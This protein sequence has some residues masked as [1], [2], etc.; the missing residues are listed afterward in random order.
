MR[1]RWWSRRTRGMFTGPRSVFSLLC[2]LSVGLGVLRAVEPRWS[3][4]GLQVG[5]LV[6]GGLLLSRHYVRGLI[7]VVA[8]VIAVAGMS[9]RLYRWDIP[10]ILAPLLVAVVGHELA[11]R[12]D[13]LGLPAMRSDEMLV[14]LRDR[15]RAQGEIPLLP[16]GWQVEVSLRSAGGAAFAGDFVTSSLTNHRPG[17]GRLEL[18]LVDVSGK[19]VAAGTRALLLSGA[20]G[21]LIGAVEPER[22]LVEANRYLLRQDWPEG[23][24]T[25]VHVTLDLDTGEYALE[26]AGHPPAVHF[27]AGSGQ[28][29]VSEVHGPLLGVFPEV[30][31]VR[32]T[33]VLGQGDALLIYTDGLVEAPGRDIDVG[34]D[35]LLGAAER[36]VPRGGFG[37]GAERLVDEV[38]GGALDDRG[39]VLVWRS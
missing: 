20:L 38:A 30:S 4:L 15:L 16:P 29:R 1:T 27:E 31:F 32:G 33:G 34:L 6:A 35:R 37:G 25:A 24:A 5:P 11:R 28:W 14:E 3:P 10:A 2:L 22:F 17:A 19:G 18:S 23:F 39:L 26:S 9:G 13:R 21:G 36:L 8:V 12:R 7:A